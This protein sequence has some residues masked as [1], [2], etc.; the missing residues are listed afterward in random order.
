MTLTEVTTVGGL[1]GLIA[2]VILLAWQTRSVAQQT[3]I[4]NAIAGTSALETTTGD[5]REVL[6]LF[7]ERPALRAYFYDSK[8]LP[9]SGHTRARVIAVAEILGDTLET[10]LVAN[11][12]IPTTES[13]DDWATYSGQMLVTSPALSR[14]YVTP[15]AEWAAELGKCR[16]YPALSGH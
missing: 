6:L 10:G 5:L 7:V 12:L 4:S 13:F 1:A 8:S 16:N 14:S 2:S 3:K 11:R 15:R 9:R